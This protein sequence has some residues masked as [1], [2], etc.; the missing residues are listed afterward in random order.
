MTTEALTPRQLRE[1]VADA[2]YKAEQ[3]KASRPAMTAADRRN[4]FRRQAGWPPLR[5]K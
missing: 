4:F 2:A 3:A 1:R 5:V